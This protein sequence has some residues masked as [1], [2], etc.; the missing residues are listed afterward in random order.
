M[1]IKIFDFSIA[2]RMKVQ[3]VPVLDDNFSYLLVDEATNEALAVD[4]AV[5][6]KYG[7]IL[8]LSIPVDSLGVVY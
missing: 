2:D 7:S 8:H 3:I 6:E 5:P 1:L 4:P